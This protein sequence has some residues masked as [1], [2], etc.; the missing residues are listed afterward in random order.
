MV[1]KQINPFTNSTLGKKVGRFLYLLKKKNGFGGDRGN[2]GNIQIRSHTTVK[3][4][5]YVE[6]NEMLILCM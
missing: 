3:N 2:Y 4:K 5:Y 1:L 6:V